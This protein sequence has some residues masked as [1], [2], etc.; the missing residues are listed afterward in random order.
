MAY[1]RLKDNND[2]VDRLMLA[3]V[4]L[5]LGRTASFVRET[6]DMPTYEAEEIIERL[7]DVFEAEKPYL[8][9]RWFSEG[10]EA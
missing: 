7:C 2:G 3:M 6:Y 5:Y 9:E 10:K 4:P 1:R 8:L